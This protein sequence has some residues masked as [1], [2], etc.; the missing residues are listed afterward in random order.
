VVLAV[1]PEICND[2]WPDAGAPKEARTIVNAHYRMDQPVTL[3]WEA[4]FVGVIGS[5]THWIFVRD[6]IVSLTISAGDALADKPNWEIANL[7]WA[8]TAKVIGSSAGRM[9]PW[10]IIK[11]R[12]A[13][14]AQTPEQ[15]NDRPGTNTSLQNLFLA[16]DWTDTGLPATIDG[17]V[18][19]GFKAARGALD[20]IRKAKTQSA[21]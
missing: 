11:E 6:N 9:P 16:G 10:R 21:N 15:V 7:L 18:K 5:E 13:T 19:S 14:F 20:A 4:P 3:P 1:P 12:R 8:E 17:S 2:I